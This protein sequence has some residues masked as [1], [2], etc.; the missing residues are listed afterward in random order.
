[1]DRIKRLSLA[2]AEKTAQSDFIQNFVRDLKSL[3]VIWAWIVMALFVWECIWA[4]LF[5]PETIPT[6]V[7]TTGGLA[8]VVTTGYI[9]SRS[10]DK[11]NGLNGNGSPQPNGEENA[12]GD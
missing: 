6:V 1:M 4:M 10:W 5:H 7:T 9:L 11:K 8:G 2:L 12:A 3:R